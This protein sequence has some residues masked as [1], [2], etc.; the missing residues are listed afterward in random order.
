MSGYDKLCVYV[1]VCIPNGEIY[2]GS[3]IS[4]VIKAELRQLDISLKRRDL[5]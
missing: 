1:C 2:I 4:H 5:S 3:M